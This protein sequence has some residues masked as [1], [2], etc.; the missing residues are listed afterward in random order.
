MK[1]D[2]S[3]IQK[4]YD[5]LCC[6]PHLTA[7]EIKLYTT[8]FQRILRNEQLRLLQEHGRK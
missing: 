7:A 6:E 8:F 4:I 3:D 1:I 5:E 2:L